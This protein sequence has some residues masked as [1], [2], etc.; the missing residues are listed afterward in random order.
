MTKILIVAI[1]RSMACANASA[2]SLLSAEPNADT[3]V[4]IDSNSGVVSKIGAL[5]FDATGVTDLAT[6]GQKLYFLSSAGTIGSV[7]RL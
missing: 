6:K 7:D 5:G 4:S 3:L 2:I 1:A